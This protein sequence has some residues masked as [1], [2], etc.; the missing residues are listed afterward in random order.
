MGKGVVRVYEKI[1]HNW[2]YPYPN[3]KNVVP[4]WSVY[5]PKNDSTSYCS[6]SMIAP[7][8]P[9]LLSKPLPQ[10]RLILSSTMITI[11]SLFQ[12]PEKTITVPMKYVIQILQLPRFRLNSAHVYANRV[13]QLQQHHWNSLHMERSIFVLKLTWKLTRKHSVSNKGNLLKILTKFLKLDRLNLN[14]SFL[15]GYCSLNYWN[16]IWSTLDYTNR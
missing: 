8:S 2:Y 12:I 14:F 10:I 13:L 6:A 5:S 4:P 11:H 1:Q 7:N 15:E 16:S 9:S 3:K